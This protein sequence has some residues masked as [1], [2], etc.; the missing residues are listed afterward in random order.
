MVSF[1]AHATHTK[2]LSV[3][4][5]FVYTVSHSSL[6]VVHERLNLKAHGLFHAVNILQIHGLYDGIHNKT[7]PYTFQ[8]LFDMKMAYMLDP[9][10]QV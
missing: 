7:T 6:S 5:F 8:E 4:A 2:S 9:E 1:M 3:Y 10:G